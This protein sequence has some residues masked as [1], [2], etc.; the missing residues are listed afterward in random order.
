MPLSSFFSRS[1]SDNNSSHHSSHH[2]SHQQSGGLF[3]S[4]HQAE[5]RFSAVMEV[6]G[7]EVGLW[8]I[9][10]ADGTMLHPK[11]Q[12]W[13][14]NSLAQLL[15]AK[16]GASFGNTLNAWSDRIHPDDVA[17]I[18]SAFEL[19]FNDR[20]GRTDYS[21]I[22]RLR[23]NDGEYRWFRTVGKTFRDAQGL[24]QRVMGINI[25][26][27]EQTLREAR[28]NELVARVQTITNGA[29]AGFWHVV[30]G[31]PGE[32][33]HPATKLWWSDWLFEITNTPRPAG[34]YLGASVWLQTV[35]P[36][37]FAMMSGGFAS[38]VAGGKT[39]YDEVY[40]L[41]TTNGYRTV[42]TSGHVLRDEQ[43]R[44]L[45]VGGTIVDISAERER[46]QAQAV[47]ASLIGELG[48]AFSELQSAIKNLTSS[49]NTIA[50]DIVQQSEQTNEI[51]SAIEEMSATLSE[52]AQ[53]TMQVSHQA[54]AASAD[55]Q[56]G[57]SVIGETVQGMTRVAE[58]ALSSAETVERLGKSSESIGEVI[59]TIEEIADQT[60]L[61]ALN[62]AIEAARA[63]DAGRGFAV[64][65]DEV[66]KLAERTQ[67]AT[68]EIS[69]TIQHIQRDTNTAVSS[70]RQSTSEVERGK[71]L[72]SQT[73][74]ALDGIITKTGTVSE[75]IT[76]LAAAIEE[77]SHVVQDIAR[78]AQG[79][80]NAIGHIGAS[81][82]SVT[83]TT[84]Q[85][86]MLLESL[87]ALIAQLQE[88]YAGS[89]VA[90]SGANNNAG[91]YRLI[92]VVKQSFPR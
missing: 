61:L 54:I 18:F 67:T 48:G 34:E 13:Y 25:L 31:A 36:D 58:A 68:R 17:G 44:A 32:L 4:R 35:H 91:T 65:A 43:G 49:A 90:G 47:I 3:S 12:Y 37:D 71:E 59:R 1:S 70:M 11:N 2:S 87:G 23:H 46:E 92:N 88:S 69:A 84:S 73:V 85:L 80:S 5:E 14:S 74:H 89:T 19:H 6:M 55:A 26:I 40:R 7:D 9:Q 42:R 8:E 86:Q 33:D 83:G 81:S 39:M 20:S 79:I 22:Y 50:Q 21:V 53:Q 29:S 38:F 10:L 76:G 28:N 57:G 64:V 30:F 63:G 78:S 72:T 16:D 24:P 75:I 60:N 62:A 77:Q 51:V 56:H 27:H 66:R 41:K 15:G 45:H 52:N 82:N